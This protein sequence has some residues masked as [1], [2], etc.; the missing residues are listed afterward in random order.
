[1]TS[2]ISRAEYLLRAKRADYQCRE[3]Q[4]AAL[5]RREL[6]ERCYV[7]FSAGKDSAVVAHAAHAARPG[8]AMLM[9]DPG[10]PVHW[11]E[12]ERAA[13]LA[14]A[15]AQGWNLTLFPWDKYASAPRSGDL[16]AY[17][18]AV[19]D[20]M[21]R[22]LTAHA[23]AHGLTRRVMGLRAEE[24]PQRRMSLGRDKAASETRLCPISLWHTSDVWCYLA[25]HGLPWLSIYD[26]LGCTARNGLIGRNGEAHGRLVFLRRY[27]PS[28]FRVARQIFETVADARGGSAGERMSG[29]SELSGAQEANDEIQR[30]A[31]EGRRS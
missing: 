4:L 23:E 30:P 13:W 27:Y 19:H 9:V 21:F 7:S 2:K 31:E 29:P 1:M 6:D 12:E 5:L 17:R 8:I 28:A 26:H 14:Y 15:Q 25:T 3:R 16:A 10:C 24:S 18:A 11:T 22:D 20:A